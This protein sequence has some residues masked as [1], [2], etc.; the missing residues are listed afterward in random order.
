[1][2][3]LAD[4]LKVAGPNLLSAGHGRGSLEP[5][6]GVLAALG[7]SALGLGL[8][9]PETEEGNVCVSDAALDERESFGESSHVSQASLSVE[10]TL[11]TFLRC[12]RT[13]GDFFMTGAGVAC[14][15]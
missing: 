12:P 9:A 13:L 10:E 8:V 7:E 5:P 15:V 1:M 2:R 3:W 6:P 11:L 4:L 14:I